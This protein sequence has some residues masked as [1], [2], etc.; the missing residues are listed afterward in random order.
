MAIEN[1]Y[2][3]EEALAYELAGRFYLARGRNQLAELYLRNAH[4]AYQRW[5]AAAKV[6]DMEARYPQWLA[7]KQDVTASNAT[8]TSTGYRTGG[9]L[10]LATVMKAAQAISGEIML[11][12]LLARLME[13]VIE[14]AGAERGALLLSEDGEWVV[15]A[16]GEIR[17]R[18]DKPLR[19]KPYDFGGILALLK[20]H[21]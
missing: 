2:L 20:E 17:T 3:N 21:T 1:E 11:D 10:D 19:I 12:K 16:E 6:K 14:N 18:S 9:Y 5:G 15:K 4:Y 8:R 13:I 7:E